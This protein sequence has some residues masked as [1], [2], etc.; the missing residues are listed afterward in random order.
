MKS[1]AILLLPMLALL[2]FGCS[3]KSPTSSTTNPSSSSKKSPA[4]SSSKASAGVIDPA[5]V[6]DW[7]LAYVADTAQASGFSIL[8]WSAEGA[9]SWSV[10]PTCNVYGKAST[11]QGE[12]RV[13][14][15]GAHVSCTGVTALS[16]PWHEGDTITW[17]YLATDSQLVVMDLD[18]TSD[19]GLVFNKLPP[20][21][22]SA[23]RPS[24]QSSAPAQSSTVPASSSSSLVANSPI[25]FQGT[26]MGRPARV[27]P[28]S[29]D[30]TVATLTAD[31]ADTVVYMVATA[32][33]G[34]IGIQ[35]NDF[36][37]GTGQ[38][39]G[40]VMV[41][42]YQSDQSSV[43]QGDLDDGYLIPPVVTA[44][45]TS[46]YLRVV[47][48]QGMLGQ[49]AIRARDTV[50]SSASSSSAAS[51]SSLAF[52]PTN[53]T[54]NGIPYYNLANGQTYGD[55]ALVAGALDSVYF[56]VPTTP[57]K[58]VVVD[59]LHPTTTDVTVEAFSDGNASLSGGLIDFGVEHPTVTPTDAH[60]WFLVRAYGGFDYNKGVF[61]IR[62]YDKPNPLSGMSMQ[63]L[64]VS[65][66][67]TEATI[68]HAQD[69]LYYR[70]AVTPGVNM[71]VLWDDV[72][73]GSG[74]PPHTADVELDALD[75]LGSSYWSGPADNGYTTIN[76]VQPTMT[77]LILRVVGYRG[78]VGT[79]SLR[80]T[81]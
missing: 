32:V 26:F 65:T 58:D 45:G 11:V 30:W 24:A 46:V 23:F 73:D 53:G 67:W 10:G 8:S 74:S 63:A 68:L 66:S 41:G 19:Q 44:T 31:S 72:L 17:N 27:L 18:Q 14:V 37:Q 71:T 4:S 70:V 64:A 76:T 51:S 13:A 59:L 9:M 15:L 22:S 1:S 12:V 75:T 43:W 40:D 3:K 57:G 81:N 49:F 42:A 5:M 47:P 50:L 28:V 79:F 25:V 54:Y 16:L 78:S 55:G 2:A 56:V 60:S 21:S 77:P 7:A 38:F 20:G 33:G 6:G 48:Y 35:W 69:T 80:V 52:R 62:V 29:A 61:Q 39:P 34:S 36:G